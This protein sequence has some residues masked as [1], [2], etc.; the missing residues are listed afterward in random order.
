MAEI[1]ELLTALEDVQLDFSSLQ[2]R[3]PLL[4]DVTAHKVD[5]LV[6][7]ADATVVRR[8]EWGVT[9]GEV[10][11]VSTPVIHIVIVGGVQHRGVQCSRIS[12]VETGHS[13]RQRGDREDS[14]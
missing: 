9:G 11:T 12:G 2:N 14:Q 10:C 13:G 5:N 4:Y 1:L 3:F 8:G 7:T 6:Q